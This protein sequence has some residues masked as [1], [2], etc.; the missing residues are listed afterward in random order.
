MEEKLKDL[1]EV[2]IFE[3]PSIADLEVD[4]REG[5][6]LGEMLRLSGI[7]YH[8]YHV[9]NIETLSA[10]F[11]LLI[12]RTKA[13]QE[14][15]GAVT[16]HFSMHGNEDG[17]GLTSGQFVTWEA[18]AQYLIKFKNELGTINLPN[19]INYTPIT[20][21]FS[22]CHGAFAKKVNDYCAENESLYMHVLGSN[23]PIA[24]ND[25]LVSFTV[26]YH[27]TLS[28]NIKAIEAI[29]RMNFA[30]NQENAFSITL[31]K[32]MMFEE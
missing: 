5:Y 10:S 23:D 28:H 17:V 13:R 2:H 32:K 9:R 14:E 30:S 25:S 3:S 24:W 19:G 15:L 8:I 7:K 26:F 11:K 29:K 20:L 4:R 1:T 22:V 21:N 12:E 18:L 16:L 6:S 27:N 31:G